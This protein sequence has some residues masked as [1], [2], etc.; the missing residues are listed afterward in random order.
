MDSLELNKIVAAIL[1]ASVIAMVS[2]FVAGF[3]VQPPEAPEERAY[4]I[5]TP[6]EGDV[7]VG[8]ETPEPVEE[9]ILVLLASADPA[10]GESVT[11]KCTACHTFDEGGPNRVGPNLWDIV[12]RPIGGADG[13]NYSDALSGLADQTW[14][15]E[16]LDAFLAAPK[17][18]APGTKMAYAGLKKADDR[19]ELIAYMRGLS[20]DPKPLPEA[21]AAP[22]PAA[23][24]VVETASEVV[25]ETAEE[26]TEAVTEAGEAV[27]ETAAEA[28]E[29]I[30]ETAEQAAD[31][32]AETA[33]E[34][35]TDVATDTSDAAE[36]ASNG[37]ETEA[38]APSETQE[39]AVP[40]S[41]LL[42]M[43]AAADPA[44]GQKVARKCRACH[45]FDS[46]GGNRVGPP[47]YGVL[48]RAVAGVEGYT[49]SSAFKAKTEET[50]NYDNMAAFL[51][52]PREWAPG[53]KMAFAGLRKEEDVAAMIAYLRQQHDSPPA[54]PE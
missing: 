38:A 31:S 25:A 45:S 7:Q 15:Y 11:R 13:F 36:A 17:A 24:T 30:A 27:A 42:A 40:A 1:T 48:G 54:L 39:A 52:K 4:V 50:W 35:A 12:G 5:A 10:A 22:E 49:Y 37:T 8:A 28:G 32:V 6:G 33:A 43:I 3:V 9:S 14:S 44:A 20:N 16:N 51:A 46:G 34:I 21:E 19:A 26:A 18:W 53:T 2:G 41:G 29:A 23:E 47:L